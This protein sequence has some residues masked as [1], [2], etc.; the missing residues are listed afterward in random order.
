MRAKRARILCWNVN[1]LRID[2]VLASPAAMRYVADAFIQP[3][4]MGSDHCPVGVDVDQR[5]FT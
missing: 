2:Y 5:I 4:V 1:G 3:E